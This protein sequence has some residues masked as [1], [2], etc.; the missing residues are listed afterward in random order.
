[1]KHRYR[2]LKLNKNHDEKQ[3]GKSVFEQKISS[4]EDFIRADEA[5]FSA[6]L[7]R[8]RSHG[9]DLIKRGLVK[10]NKRPVLRP[11]KSVPKNELQLLSLV[12]GYNNGAVSRAAEKLSGAASAFH[13]NFK[14]KT[15][16]DV[17]SSTGGFTQVALSLGAKKVIAVEVGT[18]QMVPELRNDP[19]VELHEKTD[20]R[21]F[22]TDQKID[23]VVIDVSFIS[24]T[25][26]LPELLSLSKTTGSNPDII[27]MAKPQ[28][29]GQP[30]DLNSGVIKN[31][32]IR[33]QILKDLEQWLKLNG[34][35]IKL[36][37]D[38]SLSGK[39]GNEERF[40]WL[41]ALIRK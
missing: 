16:L 21:D 37:A 35:V 23:A 4:S 3:R 36:K 10:F 26:I 20:I 25:K 18:N 34:F 24:L 41:S 6:G 40:Y 38:S 19:R 31:S 33:R 32:A 1:M 9:A 11:S 8:S 27:A 15:V 2:K 39:K 7:A 17:G 13:F 14:D 12:E 5:L 22:K 29:E 28:F 30:S